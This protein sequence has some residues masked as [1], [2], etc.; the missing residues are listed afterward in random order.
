M[1]A[2]IARRLLLLFPT[3]LGISFLIFLTIHL[4]PGDPARLMLGERATPEAVAELRTELGL[5]RPFLVQYGMYLY[6]LVTFDLGRSLKTKEPITRELL[7]R[8]PH[9]I[10]L[11]LAAM[12]VATIGGIGLGVYSALRAGQAGDFVSMGIA[13]C[14]VSMPIFWLGIV[15]M[16]T[17][18]LLLPTWTA[19]LQQ[20]YAWVPVIR[21]PPSGRISATSEFPFW[22][23]FYLTESLFRLQPRVFWDGFRHLLMPAVA[24]GT[25]PL[26]IIARMTRGC[27]LEVLRQDYIRVAR[28]KGLPEWQ[29]VLR[30]GLRN[31]LLPVITVIALQF[32]YLLGGAVITEQIF[33]WPG[34]GNYL[35]AAVNARD[36]RALQGGVLLVATCFV[37]VNLVADLLYGY[38][39]PKVQYD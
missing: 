10:E 30:H 12:L 19:S 36:Y 9:T 38:V 15:L 13:V 31:A 26:A 27:V 29:V 32:G 34:I 33:A 35:L 20:S 23:S 2:Y 18:S 21:L 11:A 37:L 8:F 4:I 24:L 7:D 6:D 14:G 17:F 22:T 5:D 1:T 25:I 39:N 28:A 3:L 16:L